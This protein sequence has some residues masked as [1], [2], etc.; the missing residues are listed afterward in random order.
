MKANIYQIYY[1]EKTKGL[2]DPGFLPFDNLANPRGDW[3]EY[4]AIRNFFLNNS[5][6]EDELYGFFSPA[7]R[8]KTHLSAQQVHAFIEQNPGRDV[9]T[10]SPFI[11]D[12]A[13][14]LNVFEQGNRYHPGHLEVVQAFLKDIALDIDLE[15]FPMTFRSTVYCNYIVAKPK[16]WQTWFALTERIFDICEAGETELATLLVSLT[17]YRLPVGMK[18]F[19]VE[20]IASL[21]LAL[22]PELSVCSYDLRRMPWSI[23]RYAPFAEQMMMLDALKTEYIETQDAKTLGAFYALRGAILTAVDG[24]PLEASKQ[25]FIQTPKIVTPKIMYVCLAQDEPAVPYPKHVSRVR[26]GHHQREGALNLR[27]LARVAEQRYGHLGALAGYFGI[28]EYIQTAGLK[29]RRVGVCLPD[30]FVTAP[31][32]PAMTPLLEDSV[33]NAME[34]ESRDFM[35]AAV[36]EPG[37]SDAQP[38]ATELQQFAAIAAELGMVGHEQIDRIVNPGRLIP[39]GLGMGVYQTDFWVDAIAKLERVVSEHLSR[40]PGMRTEAQVQSLSLCAERLGSHLVLEHFES[41]YAHINWQAKFI[42]QLNRVE[43]DKTEL[44]ISL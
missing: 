4:W 5:L 10:F 11:Q 42:G 44:V 9:Y 13:C 41:A 8:N 1:D 36:R 20:R 29:V 25:G 40:S 32:H 22:S 39:G 18:V 3:R 33:K 17:I 21:V 38:D 23:A 43:I 28:R 19:L 6:N 7:F 35:V 15:T 24:A 16:F 31:G 37:A 30:T 12:A 27:N 14:Y 34:P 26:L 2:I